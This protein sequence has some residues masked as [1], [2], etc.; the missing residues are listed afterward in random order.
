MLVNIPVPWSIWVSTSAGS[1][2]S[3][4]A[5][6]R[7]VCSF[8]QPTPQTGMPNAAAKNIS[9]EYWLNF[10][11]I[12]NEIYK[13]TKKYVNDRLRQATLSFQRSFCSHLLITQKRAANHPSHQ[14]G[15]GGW[16]L[17][18]SNWVKR[19]A[20]MYTKPSNRTI[21][22]KTWANT[23]VHIMKFSMVH[24]LVSLVFARG[25]NWMGS[26]G[27][28]PWVEKT[29]AWGGFIE[30]W[31]SQMVNSQRFVLRTSGIESQQSANPPK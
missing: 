25:Q 6:V 30:I 13:S 18:S 12:E 3:T 24:V 8:T 9:L 11:S 10:K 15:P 19:R 21:K 29:N 7:K 2:T 14:R 28:C 1:S 26:E 23:K 22:K 5:L 20:K 17:P 4:K 27:A 16:F 31:L